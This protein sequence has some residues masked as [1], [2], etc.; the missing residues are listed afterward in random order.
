MPM[1]EMYQ[2]LPDGRK[3]LVSTFNSETDEI[4]TV[5]DAAPVRLQRESLR[6]SQHVAPAKPRVRTLSREEGARLVL[7]VL[8][9]D[10]PAPP[11]VLG[12]VVKRRQAQGLMS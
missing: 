10:V 4:T 1:F 9:N 5:H 11:D 12:E 2:P 3:K 7:A 8:T 6:T